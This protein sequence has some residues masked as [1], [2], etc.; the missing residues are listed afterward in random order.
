MSPPPGHGR[1]QAVCDI[2]DLLIAHN[3]STKNVL[4]DKFSIPEDKIEILPCGLNDTYDVH[5]RA[6]RKDNR[7]HFLY[8]GRIRYYKGLDTL[9]KAVS[10]WIRKQGANACSASSGNSFPCWIPPIIPK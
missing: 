10:R 4:I 3:E 1:I 6:A 2:C 9:L 8:F 5:A 7:K